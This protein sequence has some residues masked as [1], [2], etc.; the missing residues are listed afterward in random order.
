VVLAFDRGRGVEQYELVALVGLGFA[1][2]ACA[3]LGALIVAQDAGNR[4]GLA[5]LGGGTAAACWLFATTWVN[6]PRSST[7]P[8]LQWAAW[9]DNWTFADFKI[10]HPTSATFDRFLSR[11]HRFAHLERRTTP[12]PSEPAEREAARESPRRLHSDYFPCWRVVT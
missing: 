1:A 3:A 2:A 5:F 8:L 4:L 12:R 6:V 9:L 10:P 7:R 11:I